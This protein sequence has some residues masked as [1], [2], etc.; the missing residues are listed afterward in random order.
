MLRAIL[1]AAPIL[2]LV[3]GGSAADDDPSK[4]KADAA[5]VVV[6]INADAHTVT[7]KLKDADG[8]EVEKTIALPDAAHLLDDAGQPAALDKF[9]PGAEVVFTERGGR[10]HELRR[11]A[12]RAARTLA[13][14]DEFFQKY[15]ANKDGFLQK[16]EL[17]AWLR[18][19]FDEIDTNKDGKISKEELV[20]AAVPL[21]TRRTPAELMRAYVE[22]SD[23]DE[24]CA[25]DLQAVYDFLR[26]LD[27][28]NDGK[29]DADELK[30]ARERLVG[31]RV[32]G[33]L[34][35]LDKNGDGKISKEEARGALRRDFDKLDLNKDGFL[36]RD[37]LMKAASEAPPDADKAP[38]KGGEKEP[39]KA[40]AK[41]KPGEG[42]RPPAGPGPEPAKKPGEGDR[43]PA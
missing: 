41:K 23:C 28:N 37:E 27:R 32:D 12:R 4:D 21:H 5:A 43:P 14:V 31:E 1:F 17:P 8:K 6:K 3:A 33:L 29:I 26:T 19:R 9:E 30:A 13:G 42:D 40:P 2:A 15:D 10:L 18:D 16:E 22:M 24:C 39:D 34:K 36:D 20:K 11:A 38:P 25:R 35:E 7:L